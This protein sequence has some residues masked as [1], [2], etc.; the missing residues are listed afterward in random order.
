[1]YLRKVLGG[2][3]SPVG[4]TGKEAASRRIGEGW[5]ETPSEKWEK[6][7][8]KEEEDFIISLY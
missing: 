4:L 1:M 5:S 6:I 8:E 3:S 2:L 7:E